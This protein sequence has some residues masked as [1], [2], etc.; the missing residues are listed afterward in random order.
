MRSRI[1]IRVVPSSKLPQGCSQSRQEIVCISLSWS[2][3]GCWESPN[4]SHRR[5]E[6]KETLNKL[7][8][9]SLGERVHY[10]GLSGYINIKV[11]AVE[12][13]AVIPH[14][15]IIKSLESSTIAQHVQVSESLCPRTYFVSC[16]RKMRCRQRQLQCVGLQPSRQDLSPRLTTLQ[17]RE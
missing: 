11:C 1:R 4:F 16:Q 10:L 2:N 17:I 15:L 13:K 12:L 6:V 14:W 8:K 7:D 3:Y 9:R 5:V